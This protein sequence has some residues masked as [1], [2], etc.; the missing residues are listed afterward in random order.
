MPRGIGRVGAAVCTIFSHRRQDF[1][2]RAVSITFSRAETWSRIS[3]TSSPTRRRV[4]PQ[5][6][7][8]SPGLSTT[9]SRGVV[10]AIRGLPR[11]RGL[12]LSVSTSGGRRRL[13]RRWLG[14]R[15]GHRHFET[16]K[17]QMQLVDLSIDP[18]RPAAETLAL[19]TLDAEP[20]RRN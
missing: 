16:P 11:R 17:H 7:Q 2:S 10:A 13:Q 18:L 12:A 19:K 1:F 5:S 6:G 20:Q 8:R 4:P 15:R 9:R 14:A 3:A